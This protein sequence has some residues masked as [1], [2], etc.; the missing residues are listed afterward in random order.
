MV[1]VLTV[2]V[3]MLKSAMIPLIPGAQMVGA[4]FL[5]KR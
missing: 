2:S 1:R 4:R 3:V 5:K